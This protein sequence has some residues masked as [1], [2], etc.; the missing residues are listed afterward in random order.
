MVFE[1]RKGPCA[2]KTLV[3]RFP[4]WSRSTVVISSECEIQM[5]SGTCHWRRALRE[6]CSGLLCQHYCL[7][8]SWASPPHLLHTLTAVMQD[9]PF[10]KRGPQWRAVSM[11]TP[12]FMNGSRRLWSVAS[13]H[14]PLAPQDDSDSIKQTICSTC[15]VSSF[16]T[17]TESQV[18][19][20]SLSF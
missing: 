2:L 7:L 13:Q 10:R 18:W 8:V 1:I 20:F 3:W 12:G 5:Q 6:S 14:P 16:G 4:V 15:L 17:L 19:I 11:V 9:N